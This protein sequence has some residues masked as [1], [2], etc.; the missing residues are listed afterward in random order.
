MNP[1]SGFSDWVLALLPRLFL[2]P[3]APALLLAVAL[4][5]L[6]DRARS[7][8]TI[9]GPHALAHAFLRGNTLA[10]ATAWV[11]VA[12]VP[13][14]GMAPLPFPV[15][16]F[17]LLSLPV[18]SLA[19]DLFSGKKI[20]SQEIGGVLALIVAVPALALQGSRLFDTGSNEGAAAWL[21]LGSMACGLVALF[22]GVA[23]G[24]SGAMR[25]L[26]LG[27]IGL[28]IG[29]ALNLT[30]VAGLLA[31]AYVLGALATRFG[32][33]KGVLALAYALAAFAV[34]TRLLQP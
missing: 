15:D 31:G 3:G 27:A 30:F 6:A 7:N 18:A 17:A 11:G 4:Y 20:E 8:P 23:W 10:L 22:P 14:P 24:I 33:G 28:E 9:T 1:L 26:T 32:W 19:F 34:L 21:G 16:T 25:W 2:L 13:F 5:Y 12:L 29:A